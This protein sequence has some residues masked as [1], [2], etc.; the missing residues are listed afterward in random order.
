MSL[1][2]AMALLAAPAGVIVRP[3]ANL[4]S[5]PASDSDVVSQAIYGS[6]VVLIEERDGWLKVQTPDR[7]SGW[8]PSTAV[9][10]LGEHEKP[11]AADGIVAQVDS[12][13]ANLYLEPD[14]TR[15]QPLLTVPFET[16]LEVIS[17]PEE[18]DRRWIG[19]RLPDGAE[20]W[21]QRGDVVLNPGPLDIGDVIAL[22]KRFLGLPYLWGGSSS[23][24][25]DCSGYTQMLYRRLGVN[26]PRDSGPQAGWEGFARV[27]RAE[28][29]PGDLV[30][31]GKPGGKITHTGMYIGGGEF[32]H[33]TAYK[34]PVVQVSRLDDPHWGELLAAC[35]R[36]K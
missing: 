20:V 32:I 7:Y 4:Y 36:L 31:F 8:T 26:I 24:G 3:V 14:V 19:V 35:R 18:E 28:L 30:F 22:S 15:R 33:A 16:R 34:R 5:A 6:G 29:E 12:L 23:F 10:R 11:Y 9:K 17:Q 1:I 2:F 25:Y 21:V 27:E 13:F